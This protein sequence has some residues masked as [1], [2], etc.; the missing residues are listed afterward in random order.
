MRSNPTTPAKKL[1]R[2]A[3]DTFE[4]PGVV[5]PHVC[6]VHEPLSLSLKDIRELADGALPESILKP[7][8]SQILLAIDYL[9]SVAHVVHTDIQE[10]NVMLSVTDQ[11][12]FDDA[13]DE[14]W[15]EP[16]PRKTA[17]DHVVHTS[18]P[19]D[20]PDDPGPPVIIDFGDAQFGPGPFIGEVMPDLYR[21]PEIILAIPWDEKID[22]WALGLMIWDMFEGRHLFN[23]R[24]PS[25]EA[26]AGAHLA[27]IISLLGPPPEDLL[28][29]GGATAEFFDRDGVF[30][31]QDQV[32]ESSLGSEEQ[33]L[34]G[35]EKVDFL[36]FLGKMLQ[37]RPEDRFSA[38]EL[39][40]DP[41][42]RRQD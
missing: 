9:H 24:L 16:M 21:A 11:S 7:V 34:D 31:I 13:V 33:K 35:E 2:L 8:V 32:M 15:G 23:K 37:W 41:W 14:E 10:G 30:K 39:M 29:K 20:M 28:K 17:N 4:V 6:I 27:R 40:K 18:T 38:R 3:L 5:G 42:L 22:I 12:I 1:V 19:L 26:S 25:R 36:A